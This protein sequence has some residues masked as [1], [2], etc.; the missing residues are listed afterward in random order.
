MKICFKQLAV[1]PTDKEGNIS[2]NSEYEQTNRCIQIFK[3]Y[4]SLN[5]GPTEQYKEAIRKR[6]KSSQSRT[7]QDN[8]PEDQ[9]H[10]QLYYTSHHHEGD[11]EDEY[12]RIKDH[13]AY[14]LFPLDVIVSIQKVHD[15]NSSFLQKPQTFLKLKLVDPII[16]MLNNQF[17][18]YLISLTQHMSAMQ[19]VQKNLHIRP[20]ETPKENVKAWWKYAIR[21]I[22]EEKKRNESFSQ[23]SA[24]KLVKMR[25][26]INLYKRK[27]NLVCHCLCFLY[28]NINK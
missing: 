20:L 17:T 5:F 4:V 27:Q 13:N 25:T 7:Q 21:A 22:R 24:Q 16:L 28:T 15:T 9:S 10:K 3:L 2:Q 11:L 23:A 6:E 1:Y 8:I 26:Y 19:I 12:H 18:K 14:F